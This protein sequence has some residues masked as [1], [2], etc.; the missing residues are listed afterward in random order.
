LRA[1]VVI[2]ASHFT[3]A[4]PDDMEI[5]A[6]TTLALLADRGDSITI[7]T[8]TPGDCGSHDQ[9]SEAI[10]AVRRREAASAAQR[11]GAQYLYLEMRISRFLMTTPAAAG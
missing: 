11:I 2:Y 8:F 9:G 3:H 6:G 7:A 4:H 5:L 10:A 1:V